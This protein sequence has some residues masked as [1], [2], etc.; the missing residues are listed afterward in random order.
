MNSKTVTLPL[1]VFLHLLAQSEGCKPDENKT[2]NGSSNISV[3]ILSVSLAVCVVLL[4]MC[5]CVIFHLK[6]KKAV[7][8]KVENIDAN[9]DYGEGEEEEQYATKVVDSNDYYD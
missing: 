6:Q 4:L 5:G 7:Q 1:F 2:S 3:I 8:S 9:P